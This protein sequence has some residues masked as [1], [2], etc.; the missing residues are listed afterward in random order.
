MLDEPLST[1]RSAPKN[2]PLYDGE[3]TGSHATIYNNSQ[4]LD[5]SGY[6]VLIQSVFDEMHA[7]DTR[8]RR[9]MPF[10]TFQH[11]C[12]EIL[13]AVIIHQA[14]K[15]GNR[16]FDDETDPFDILNINTLQ[17]PAPIHEYLRGICRAALQNGDTVL[18]NLPEQGTPQHSIGDE[19]DEAAEQAPRL[20]SGSFGA[21]TQ[22]SH[23]AYESYCSPLIS[24]RL[25]EQTLAA[26][27]REPG[28]NF[29]AWQPLDAV[30]R[31]EGAICTPNLLGYRVPE[32]LTPEGLN[33]LEGLTFADSDDMHGRIAHSPELMA[34]V[35]GVLASKS[36][37]FTMVT[38]VDFLTT[39]SASVVIAK[40]VTPVHSRE[41]L[42][43]KP[44]YIQSPESFGSAIANKANYFQ[45]KRLRTST[46]PGFCMTRANGTQI[47]GWTATINENY[48]MQGN[49]QAVIGVDYAFLRTDRFHEA[50]LSGEVTLTIRNWVRR[51]FLVKR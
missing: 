10:A 46:A 40:V 1:T 50:S 33:I 22:H 5:F 19:A 15:D 35:N 8:L 45:Y 16:T 34:R 51:H 11:Y 4:N 49:Y 7:E 9:M 23:N 2:D 30:F 25:V 24:R 26:N 29:G 6:I 36:E 38:G 32:H 20:P 28:I 47:P 48:N 43:N 44:P 3:A 17:I 27:S 41:I 21:I 12:F 42:A 18:F 39:N 14:K 13:N 37:R 31:P